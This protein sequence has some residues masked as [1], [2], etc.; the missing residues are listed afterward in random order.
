MSLWDLKLNREKRI[1]GVMVAKIG[2][3]DCEGWLGEAGVGLIFAKRF[4]AAIHDKR[5]EGW[6][7]QK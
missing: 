5:I 1:I 3:G 4:F 6:M 7:I 2:V